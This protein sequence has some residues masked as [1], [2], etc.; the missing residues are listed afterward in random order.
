MTYGL[1]QKQCSNFVA[2]VPAQTCQ[3]RSS[4]QVPRKHLV[5]LF[6]VRFPNS[7]LRSYAALSS[8]LGAPAQAQNSISHD[9]N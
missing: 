5:D 9:R 8:I 1:N 3:V 4:V 2:L 7:F 6:D